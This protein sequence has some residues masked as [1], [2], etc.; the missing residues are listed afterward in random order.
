[1]RCAVE[2]TSDPDQLQA[3][4]TWWLNDNTGAAATGGSMPGSSMYSSGAGSLP[5]PTTA[6]EPVEG[7]YL[8]A[9]LLSGKLHQRFPYPSFC[10][11]TDTT[12]WNDGHG[13]AIPDRDHFRQLEVELAQNVQSFQDLSNR[14]APWDNA[15]ATCMWTAEDVYSTIGLLRNTLWRLPPRHPGVLNSTVMALSVEALL[16]TSRIRGQSSSRS[17][18]CSWGRY[19]AVAFQ[20]HHWCR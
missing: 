5:W 11:G 17:F 13:E 7:E 15:T 9:L 18:V 6:G 2:N 20:L 1:V 10:T 16:A 14:L 8:H 4:M 3:T 12:S 19:L